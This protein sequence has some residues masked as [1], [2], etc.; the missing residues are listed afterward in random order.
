MITCFFE[1]NNK[2]F[3]RHITVDNIV[4]KNNEILLVKRASDTPAHP[5]KYALP[6]GY[7]DRNETIS[8]G[9]LRE[10]EEETGYK[11]KIVSL[12]RINSNPDRKGE[13]KQNVDFV[14]LIEAKEKVS[15]PDNEISEVV[16]F[17]LNNL[18]KPEE[19]GFDHYEIIKLY[20]KH[21]E[22]PFSLPIFNL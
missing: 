2:A 22:K 13:D 5:N 4:I 10:F 11:G 8:Q 18:P 14:Y 21:K 17:D 12:F 19:F 6:G 9:A 20:L 3:L 7:L 16:W 1:N 15:E